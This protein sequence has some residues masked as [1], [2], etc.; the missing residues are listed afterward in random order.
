MI[1]ISADAV[2]ERW[3]DLP[4]DLR[5]FILSEELSDAID[6]ACE[7]QGITDP[8]EVHKLVSFRLYGLLSVE[9]F[10]SSL[11]EMLGPD[12][13]KAVF[14]S[15]M[16]KVPQ[17][18]IEMVPSNAAPATALSETPTP[19]YPENIPVAVPEAPIT[20][21]S[22]DVPPMTVLPVVATP[23]APEMTPS[24]IPSVTEAA[25]QP[26][27]PENPVP[28]MAIPEVP[29]SMEPAF[30]PAPVPK[31]ASPAPTAAPFMLHQE[32]EAQAVG[33][34]APGGRF[35]PLRPS[36]YTPSIEEMRE[37]KPS[38]ARLQFGSSSTPTP[39]PAP[40]SPKITSPSTIKPSLDDGKG[41]VS[42]D[43]VVNLRDLPL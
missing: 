29:P 34:S 21:T 1:Q 24:S 16:T 12:K 4:F 38:F 3:D 31:P 36:F 23:T 20:P 30:V 27:Q 6:S 18:I 40:A 37:E 17:N 32:T 33:E 19:S 26:I 10:R 15:V 7:T 43:N 2:N 42:P 9:G 28:T 22:P 14:D 35:D 41:P 5:E 11:L 39:D 25:L 8:T 13:A